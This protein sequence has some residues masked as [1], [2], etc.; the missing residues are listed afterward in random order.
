MT[1]KITIKDIAER[2]GVSV[3][4]VSRVL[5]HKD[6]VSEEVAEKVMKIAKEMNY[7]FNFNARILR[8]GNS[9]IIGI[10]IP[11]IANSFFYSNLFNSC[12][13]IFSSRHK[14]FF[15]YGSGQKTLHFPILRF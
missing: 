2:A 7:S 11:D 14:E 13:S 12:V 15:L 4:T 6:G 10:I 1:K 9:K 3:A 5:N 8:S